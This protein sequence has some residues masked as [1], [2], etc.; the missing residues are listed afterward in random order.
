MAKKTV[1]LSKSELPE[2]RK[3]TR[4]AQGSHD[5]PPNASSVDKAKYEL[6]K[7]M[8][9]FMRKNSLSQRELAKRLDRT[10]TVRVA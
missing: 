3:A 7:Q 1:F 10:V 9:V 8:I 4:R 5:L 6:C 2:A